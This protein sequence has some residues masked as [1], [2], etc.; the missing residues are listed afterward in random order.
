VAETKI[1]CVSDFAFVVFQPTHTYRIYWAC[2]LLLL[3]LFL[4]E[5]V[6]TIKHKMEGQLSVGKPPFLLSVILIDI[7][8]ACAICNTIFDEGIVV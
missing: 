1:Q 6:D 3:D 2:L 5:F 4:L 7:Y 8:S